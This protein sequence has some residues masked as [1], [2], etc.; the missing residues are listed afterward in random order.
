M[1]SELLLLLSLPLLLSCLSH[2]MSGQTEV[3][4]S[5][6]LPVHNL[7]TELNYSTIQG[8]IDA[9]ET[10]D[11]YTI[12]VDSGTCYEHV[13]VSK[14]VFLLGESRNDT[15]IDGSGTGPVVRLYANNVTVADFTIRNGG[16]AFSP[17]DTC[18]FGDYL[19]NVL[20][21]N[22][23]VM[24]AS[25]GVIFYGFSNSTMYGNLAEECTVMGLHFD[26][27]TNCTMM[28]NTVTDSFQGIVLE[29]SA[30]NFIQGNYLIS[31]NVSMDFYAS[32]G[33][34]VEGNDLIN[35]S[36][37]IVLDSCNGLNNFRNN[38]MTSAA[39]NLVVWGSSLEA[40]VQDIDTS[41]MTTEQSIISSAP[42]VL[43]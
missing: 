4:A 43:R 2:T 37:G 28:D 40:F 12:E 23:T 16:Y 36:V 41:N 13:V 6:G 8:A 38:S 42:T 10:L 11:G 5:S 17:M 24:N 25:C 9:P 26:T 33:N 32:A 21:E 27:S 20:I 39:Y 15:I 14:S 22:N 31:N 7:N 35:N 34:V 18:I 3:I 1:R 30:G 29:K 19:G